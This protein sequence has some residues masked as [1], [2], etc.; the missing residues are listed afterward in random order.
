MLRFIVLILILLNGAY[1]AWS[2][3]L[4]LELGYGPMQQ[5][6]PH[7]MTQQIKPDLIRLISPQ[8]AR[9]AEL[10]ARPA[11]K[12]TE[13]LQTG[14]LNATVSAQLRDS[15]QT[16]SWPTG[17]WVLEP[18]ITPERWIIYMG[19]FPSAEFQARKRAELLA[20]NVKV[21]PL[22]LTLPSLQPGLS[23]GTFDTQEAAKDSLKD[24]TGRGVKSAKLVQER[25][26]ERGEILRLPTVDDV[27]RARLG[28]IRP[29]LGGES[30]RTCR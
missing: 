25:T 1:F 22:S 16:S 26:E 6:E 21:F 27:L 12:P 10:A 4:L 14:L 2:E 23:L 29:L 28:E 18:V 24:L 9:Q 5:T 19:K 7:R 30:L 20:L 8:E 15:L 13:C 3:G 17:S 11:P